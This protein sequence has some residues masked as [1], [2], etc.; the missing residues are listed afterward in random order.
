M[1]LACRLCLPPWQDAYVVPWSF[2]HLVRRVRQGTILAICEVP[3]N[4]WPYYLNSFGVLS[5]HNSSFLS[6]YGSSLS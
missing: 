6:V 4:P 3:L 1:T 2:V 5:T